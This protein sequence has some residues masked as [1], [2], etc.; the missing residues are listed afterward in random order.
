MLGRG[1]ETGGS[2]KDPLSR[3]RYP[4]LKS[5]AWQLCGGS[6]CGVFFGVRRLGRESPVATW[7]RCHGTWRTRG[8][9]V[10]L[11]GTPLWCAQVLENGPMIVM[12][13]DCCPTFSCCGIAPIGRKRR[14]AAAVQG[15]PPLRLAG[16]G[17]LRR[18]KATAQAPQSCHAPPEIGTSDLAL[19]MGATPGYPPVFRGTT[20]GSLVSAFG[21]MCRF[22]AV[23]S[24][25]LS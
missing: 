12:K 11:T 14:Q 13:H 8:D 19:T 17:R 2:D 6:L 1:A 24:S 23:L 21:G 4:P 9:N 25:T 10:P 15:K 3:R 5:G 16:P 22:S 7:P 18:D 20:Q